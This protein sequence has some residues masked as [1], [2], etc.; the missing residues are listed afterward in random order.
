MIETL[1]V[2]SA[3]A[4]TLTVFFCT[5]YLIAIGAGLLTSYYWRTRE[6]NPDSN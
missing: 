1:E 3:A 4:L 2:F 5:L 6:P